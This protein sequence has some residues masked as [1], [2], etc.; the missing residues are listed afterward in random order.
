[1]SLWRPL[2]YTNFWKRWLPEWLH[3][4][5][6]WLLRLGLVVLLLLAALVITY[7]ALS[8]R[9]DL[10]ELSRLQLA[11]A[12][13]DRDGQPLIGTPGHS[14]T[15][16]HRKDIPDLFVL[17]LMAREDVR[18]MSHR[19]IDLRGL[20]RAT[21]RNLKD[22]DFTQGG[23]TLTMQLA[24][25]CY[26]IE[27]S[28]RRGKV[29]QLHRKLVEMGIAVRIERR[30]NKD[31]ILTCYLNRIYFGSG[32]YGLSEAANQYF[33]KAPADLSPGQCALLAG[34]IRG[35]HLYSP[36]RN[37]DGALEQRRQ[38]LERMGALGWISAEA[39]QQAGSEP[40]LL[41]QECAGSRQA[42]HLIDAVQQELDALLDEGSA[43]GGGLRVITTIDSAWQQRLE[44]QLEAAL[45]SLE[46][47]KGWQEARYATHANGSAPRYLQYSAVTAETA[48]GAVLALIGGRNPLH[49]RYDR[50]RAKRDLG[51]AFEPF[52]AAAASENGKLVIAGKPLQTGRQAGVGEVQRIARLC[53]LEGPFADDEDLYR[54]TVAASPREIAQ[55]LAT[56]AHDG[57][58]P[59]L[60]LIAE[61]R[62]RA[63]DLIYQ[64]QAKPLEVIGRDAAV[65]GLSV[66]K[67]K[68]S[69]RTFTGATASES[70]AWALRV[71]PSGSTV[72]WLGFDQPRKIASEARLK[73][74]LDELVE[75]LGKNKS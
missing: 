31:E 12:L 23:S 43:S 74:L 57:K 7:G 53:G 49:S 17:A 50:T 32:C 11:T 21:W 38:T 68:G 2:T 63:G 69:I 8:K 34:I 37:P 25:N 10:N 64:A 66:L 56:L 36:R 22:F 27:G 33:G 14:S 5:V 6:A 26:S 62:N 45:A 52:V 70:D 47:E 54:G 58:Q 44:S 60:H 4:P 9:Y 35:P 39:L 28:T 55:G 40:L 42:S 51:S 59:K 16:V 71:G 41:A 1:M 13:C 29:A 18:F 67:R 48:S 61:I 3:A 72:I 20:M 15:Q 73:S 24:R 46:E 65:D 19:G 75:R 30:Y